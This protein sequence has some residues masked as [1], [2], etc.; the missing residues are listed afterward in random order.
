MALRFGSLLA[1][2]FAAMIVGIS[3]GDNHACHLE[4]GRNWTSYI[5]DVV[6][7][8]PGTCPVKVQHSGDYVQ[9]FADVTANVPSTT[10][11]TS[12]NVEVFNAANT[13]VAQVDQ[14]WFD[15]NGLG[16]SQPTML[17]PVGTSIPTNDDYKVDDANMTTQ[18]NNLGG[19]F[20][21][22]D[23]ALT[24]RVG[25][26]ASVAGPGSVNG[27][28]SASFDGTAT[29]G[30]TPYGY[31]WR[32]NSSV[33]GQS[34]TSFS[35]V[36]SNIGTDTVWF[37]AIDA[38]GKA[39]SASSILSVLFWADISGPAELEQ[40]TFGTWT[41]N[42]PAGTPPF[43]YDWLLDG[44]DMGSSTSVTGGWDDLG[45]HTVE[46]RAG[47]AAGHH[48]DNIFNV[49]VVTSGGCFQPPC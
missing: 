29:N 34:G 36:W 41:V 13:S 24:F 49:T 14:A 47:D 15:N 27:G 17:Y 46:M 7:N 31:Q 23:A 32:V 8:D 30:T 40:G 35:Q 5:A 2:G 19:A 16:E 12:L 3:C 26:Y 11:Q 22:A 39:D 45:S 1:V 33:Q 4:Y 18:P 9:Y 37:R 10:F 6:V 38:N 44:N 20:I 43:T 42:I 25:T 21:Q 28:N 48:A